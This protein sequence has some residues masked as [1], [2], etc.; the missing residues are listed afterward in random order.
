MERA[1]LG[2]AYHHWAEEEEADERVAQLEAELA[3]LKGQ[4][5][6]DAARLSDL[7]AQRAAKTARTS[8]SSQKMMRR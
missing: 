4:R 3:D 2:A 5:S 6:G 7:E 1:T 8:N